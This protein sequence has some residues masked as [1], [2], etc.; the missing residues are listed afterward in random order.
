MRLLMIRETPGRIEFSLQRADRTKRPVARV[1][2][3]SDAADLP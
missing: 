3:V 1:R 2:Q